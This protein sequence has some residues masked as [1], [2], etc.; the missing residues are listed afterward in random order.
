[1]VKTFFVLFYLACTPKFSIAQIKQSEGLMNFYFGMYPDNRKYTWF[2]D[3]TVIFEIFEDYTESIN[4]SIVAEGS[5]IRNYS[6]LDLTTMRAQDYLTFADT[7][8][9]LTNYLLKTNESISWDFYRTSH[10][11]DKYIDSLI[12]IPDTT[13]DGKSFKRLWFPL[14]GNGWYQKITYFIICSKL[15]NIFHM[16]RAF[17]DRHR[18]CKVS[19]IQYEEP[20]TG[21]SSINKLILIRDNLTITESKIFEKWKANLET[22]TLPITTLNEGQKKLATILQSIR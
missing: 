13:I 7:A 3:S 14:S 16:S 17:D 2:K 15:E 5:C 12:P 18:G 8:M 20:S 1:M 9:P 21:R 19:C 22:S 11:Y 6:I 10:L 4:D